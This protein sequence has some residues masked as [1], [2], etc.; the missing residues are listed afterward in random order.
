[1]CASRNDGMAKHRWTMV[2]ST[3]YHAPQ[4][5]K[6]PIINDQKVWRVVGSKSKLWYTIL[7][8]KIIKIMN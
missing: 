6:P 2:C 5:K 7:N 1:M 3:E 8:V 4:K